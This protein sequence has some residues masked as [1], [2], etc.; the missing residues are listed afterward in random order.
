MTG[1]ETAIAIAAAG[2]SAAGTLMT[3]F[4]QAAAMKANA[5]SLD[6]AGRNEVTA[7]NVEARNVRAQA[8]QE[9]GRQIA[10]AGSSGLLLEGSPLDVIFQSAS[11]MELD[12]M[13]T[14]KNRQRVAEQYFA[15]A[16]N[17]R[18]QAK[19]TRT[20]A[21]VGAGTQLLFSAAGQSFGGSSGPTG[22]YAGGTGTNPMTGLRFGG[23]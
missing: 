22:M 14:L 17:M 7:G 20:G 18:R 1:I 16:K 9:T 13:N 2:A 19:A 10:A 6:Q 23:V 11:E 5:R 21:L 15:D 12:A 4:Q 3:G 8:T